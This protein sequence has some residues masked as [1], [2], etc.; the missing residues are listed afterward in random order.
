MLQQWLTFF[1]KF[2]IGYTL[3]RSVSMCLGMLYEEQVLTAWDT[4]LYLGIFTY[5]L[6]FV[7]ARF[8]NDQ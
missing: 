5:V 8:G 1:L 2:A 3:I 6:F 4:L 7:Y